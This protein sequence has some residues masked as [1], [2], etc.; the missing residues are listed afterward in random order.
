MKV[1]RRLARTASSSGAWLSGVGL[2]VGLAALADAWPQLVMALE[3]FCS[4]TGG[5]LFGASLAALT[6]FF[7]ET[8]PPRSGS[9][10]RKKDRIH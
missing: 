4:G 8:S 9:Q 3:P 7:F 5:L 6:G 2:G 10:D 1:E